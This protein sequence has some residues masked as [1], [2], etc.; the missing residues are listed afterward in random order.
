MKTEIFRILDQ[1][2]CSSVEIKL[3]ESIALKTVFPTSNTTLQESAISGPA[4]AG[5]SLDRLNIK[6]GTGM[7][8]VFLVLRF[9][10]GRIAYGLTCS[11]CVFPEGKDQQPECGFHGM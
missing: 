5:Q 9:E 6:E 8:D 4:Q 11:L 10:E 1:F 3:R 2:E 7:L